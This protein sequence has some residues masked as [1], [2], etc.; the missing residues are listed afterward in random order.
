MCTLSVALFVV[1]RLICNVHV[2]ISYIIDI[3]NKLLTYLLTVCRS[4]HS[5]W[6]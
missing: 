1:F 5:F 6:D 4:E 2:C 3:V